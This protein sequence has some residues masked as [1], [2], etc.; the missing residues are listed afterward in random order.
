MYAAHLS[1]PPSLHRSKS[2][3]LQLSKSMPLGHPSKSMPL[4]LQVVLNHK[5]AQ[6]PKM[7][8]AGSA[9]YDLYSVVNM[10]IPP[11][12]RAVVKTGIHITVPIGTYGRIAPRSG[13]AVKDWIDVGAGV[14][15]RDYTG[16]IMVVLHNHK[17][18]LFNVRVGDRIAQLVLERIT[19]PQ[20]VQ[21]CELG[22]SK[23]GDGGFGSTGK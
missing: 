3:P 19:N 11:M 18:E 16:E 5:D 7:G 2:M 9:G 22:G 1:G 13:L 23:R 12:S 6:M 8:S 10:E 21:M 20:V 17:K 15:D 14:I 4:S